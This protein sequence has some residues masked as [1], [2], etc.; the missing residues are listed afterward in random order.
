MHP[1]RN[2]DQVFSVDPPGGEGGGVFD[3]KFPLSRI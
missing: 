1:S 3:S 2:K